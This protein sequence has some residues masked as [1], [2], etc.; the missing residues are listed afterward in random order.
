MIRRL[1]WKVVAVTMGVV[2]AVLLLALAT[3]YL[4]SRSSLEARTREQ[5]NQALQGA[6]DAPLQP[7]EGGGSMP[8]FVADVYAGGTV[9][10]S[11]SSY[12]DLNDE[13]TLIAIVQSC[14]G[15][16]EDSGVLEE[17]HLRYLRQSSMLSVRIAFTDSTLEQSTLRSLIGT[18]ALIGL[19][20]FVVLFG[21]SYLLSGLIT[22]PVER[23]WQEQQRFLSD[24]SHELKTPLTVIM[25][26]ADLLA[27]SLPEGAQGYVDNIRSESRRMKKLVEG[28]LTLARAD[29]GGQK[30]VF[31]S[32]D[33]S[34][35]VTDT[36]LLFEPVAFEA[37]RELLY[38]IQEGLR[39]S[40]DADQ[41]RQLVSILLDNAIKYAPEHSAIRLHLEKEDKLSRLTVENGGHPIPPEAVAHLFDRFYRADSARSGPGG[42][43]LG[44]SI[45]QSIVQAHGG[46][47]RC[48]SD[49]RSTR[50]IVTL[51]LLK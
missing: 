5:L 3:V 9:R 30:L 10:I 47:I 48:V 12:F 44:L 31:S 34:D 29:D 24:A 40:G 26:S 8:C 27:G 51:P 19:G 42:F 21:F 33:W 18:M 2:T 23:A 11:G 13:E 20:A 28:M 35:V 50:F 32:L 41:L 1:R 17:Y 6:P 36:A 43:G 4:S 25:S 37:G 7:G 46:D 49:E 22:R 16:Q 45:A 14:L 39:A 15:R 38:N